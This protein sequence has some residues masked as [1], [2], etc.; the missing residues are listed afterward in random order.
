MLISNDNYVNMEMTKPSY[1]VKVM[2]MQ[3]I[4][5]I[6]VETID[7]S[8]PKYVSRELVL[9]DTYAVSISDR[10]QVFPYIA[11]WDTVFTVPR[12]KIQYH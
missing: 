11:C 5:M 6:Q 10:I 7:K 8:G 12:L 2:I 1:L 4:D 3:Q 9:I